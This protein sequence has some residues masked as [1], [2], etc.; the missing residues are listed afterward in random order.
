MSKSD[1]DKGDPRKNYILRVASHLFG[2]NLVEDK[3]PNIKSIYKFCETTA[4]IFVIARH[5][6]VYLCTFNLIIINQQY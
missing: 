4:P 1:S 6:Q 3:L 5:E 2:L